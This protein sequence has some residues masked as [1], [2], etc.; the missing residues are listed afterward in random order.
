[1][2][3][4]NRSISYL[5]LFI[6]YW[7]STSLLISLDEI[8]KINKVFITLPLGFVLINIIYSFFLLKWSFLLNLFCS[9]IVGFLSFFLALKFGNLDI[10]LKYDSYNILTSIISN[11]LFSIIFWEILYQLKLSINSKV[12]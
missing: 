2:K 7:F 5:L 4:K 1:M 12:E 10:F 3:L 6:I 8:L 11:A 9:I